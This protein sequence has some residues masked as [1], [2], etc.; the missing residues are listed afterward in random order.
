M[1]RHNFVEM[2]SMLDPRWVIDTQSLL[3]YA[4]MFH[5]R[6]II[7]LFLLDPRLVVVKLMSDPRCTVAGPSFHRKISFLNAYTLRYRLNVLADFSCYF[8][9]C[10]HFKLSWHYVY[11]MRKQKRLREKERDR[12]IQYIINALFLLRHNGIDES[13]VFIWI[14]N[15]GIQVTFE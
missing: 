7:A 1:Y 5:N 9:Y 4:L 15:N 14:I 13:R 8:F 10:Q 6:S 3:Y 11:I 2:S 12:K